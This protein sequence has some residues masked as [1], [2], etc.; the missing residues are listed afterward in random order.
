M[1]D[2]EK[3]TTLMG[4]PKKTADRL[5]VSLRT[6]WNYLA[7]DMPEPMKE[8]ITFVLSKEEHARLYENQKRAS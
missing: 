5:H 8:Y 4:S 7:G 6:Y 1:T 2:L 3:L